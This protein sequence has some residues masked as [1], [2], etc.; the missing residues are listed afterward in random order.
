MEPLAPVPS[1]QPLADLAADHPCLWGQRQLSADATWVMEP[2]GVLIPTSRSGRDG[3]RWW[4]SRKQGGLT[5]QGIPILALNDVRGERTIYPL[6]TN[7][8][9]VSAI[10]SMK[11]KR[12][13]LLY[14]G[15]LF[16]HFGHLIVDLSRTY[17]LL[18]LFRNSRET[19][20]FHY[21]GQIYTPQHKAENGNSTP[22]ANPLID[23]WLRCLGIRKRVRVIRKTMHGSMLM[24]SSVLYRD[25]AFVTAD[26]P[27][28]ARA[29]LSP[30]LSR[31]LLKVERLPGRMA[32]LSRHKLQQGTT[33]FEGEQEVVEA[34][35]R[36]PNVDVICAEELSIRAK[37]KLFR[38]YQ[39]VTGFPQAAMLLKY[40]V[41][42]RQPRDLAKLF[43]FSAGPRSLNS[44]WVNFD[45]AFGFGDQVLDCSAGPGAAQEPDHQA[46][47]VQPG[48]AEGF[49]RHNAFDVGVMVDSLRALAA[50]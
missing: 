30:K 42:H 47:P 15:S 40:F 2:N 17:Q 48:Q 3:S 37:L 18:R 24:S 46:G 27:Q 35:A 12:P 9:S 49:Q 36:L 13:L 6:G 28:A 25:R 5:G 11:V 19:I 29:A 1:P 8:G 50:S 26:F 16:D 22:I 33:C 45:R 43:L 21:P 41:P 4:L 34:L 44:N 23:E 32:Y 31:R 38:Q 39:L 20:W 10:P 7:D 14:G